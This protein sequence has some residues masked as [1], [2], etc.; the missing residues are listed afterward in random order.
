M[1]EAVAPF[2]LFIVL[3]LIATGLLAPLVSGPIGFLQGLLITIFR[4]QGG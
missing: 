3:G 2:G 1:L 4:L